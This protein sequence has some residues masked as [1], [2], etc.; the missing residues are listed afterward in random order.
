[1][2][3]QEAQPPSF[4][5]PGVSMAARAC[6]QRVEA[7]DGTAS[8]DTQ[9]LRSKAA[10]TAGTGGAGSATDHGKV[11]PRDVDDEG[12]QRVH[13]RGW[14]KRKD[15][16]RSGQDDVDD[17]SGGDGGDADGGGASAGQVDG[18]AGEDGGG[19]EPSTPNTLHRAW[20]NEVAVVRRLKVQGI[21]ATHP[22]MQA[23][24]S[25]RDA[26]ERLWRDAKDPAPAAVRLARAQ[27]KLDRAI[28]L[29]AEARRALSDYEKE[30]EGK[31]AALHARLDE[32]RERVSLRRRQL[33]EIQE[34]VGA[35]GGGGRVRAAQG[36]AAKQVHAALC[37]TVA[38]T[39]AALVEQ[40]DS[41]TPAWTVLNGLLS[42]LTDSQALLEQ[43]FTPARAAQKYD[44]ADGDDG[45]WEGSEWSESHD[46]PG[47]GGG[48]GHGQGGGVDIARAPA[49]ATS[50]VGTAW[51]E[52]G[53]E[54][55]SMGPG[56]WWDSPYSG[57]TAAARWQECGHGKWAR[58]AW[59]DAWE[60][61]RE[62]EGSAAV[63]RRLEPAPP[64]GSGAAGAQPVGEAQDG[65]QRKRQ[66]DE[67]VQKIDM[68]AIDAG[69]QP[70]TADGEE[71][72]LLDPP[73]LDAW[74]TEHL[75]EGLSYW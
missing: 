25:A 42:T 58:A 40:L 14:R 18:A 24:C 9:A 26:A 34:E 12:F 47:K 57:W 13:A 31:L 17:A 73:A 38:P 54:D 43:A 53:V 74:V 65:E 4:R 71:L 67:R 20:Q 15:T 41:S 63:R 45:H 75:P 10:P 70:L 56:E 39:I 7:R 29:Q 64:A 52:G 3:K 21:A 35:E 8:G 19:G 55:Q 62:E 36:E 11:D 2:P 6:Q 61:E 60:Q 1:M 59:A 46:L 68:A 23:A 16:A 37:G 22:A 51:G 28:E 50:G 69:I 49:A 5:V 32:N 27:T 44:I 33:E 48:E 72:H 30:H 66:H